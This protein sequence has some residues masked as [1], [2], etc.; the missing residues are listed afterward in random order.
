MTRLISTTLL[1][2]TLIT[3]AGADSPLRPLIYRCEPA[4]PG[5]PN[6]LCGVAR[7]DSGSTTG[8]DTGGKDEHSSPPHID[9]NPTTAERAGITT[10]DAGPG[11]IARSLRA[12]GDVVVPP[13]Q[14]A[15]VRARF[16]GV[17]RAI[18]VQLGQTVR[19][20][21][22]LAEIESN[23][24]LRRYAVTAPIDGIVQAL[25]VVPGDIATDAPLLMLLDDRSLALELK[26]FPQ[27]RAAVAPGQALLITGASPA[28]EIT[29]SQLIPSRAG[30][31]VIARAPLDNSNGRFAPGDLLATDIVVERTE[32]AI[33]IDNRALQEVESE[34]GV[35]VRTDDGFV[36]QPVTIG[37]HDKVHSEVITGLSA[38]TPY[39][40]EN[41]Y[42]IKADLEKA[43]AT[44]DH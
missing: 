15:A 5:A 42:L 36:F 33:V 22:T 1:F 4:A 12:Y 27:Q 14:M 35:F 43:G 16:P 8:R 39:V 25:H 26:I 44:H 11:T 17:V 23:D 20:G 40:V 3:A 2:A 21:D 37:Q 9:I 31:Y 24:S 29:I 10:R 41:S 19:S 13:G 28:M 18:S 38:G 6:E 30:P 7:P 34:Q 32:A